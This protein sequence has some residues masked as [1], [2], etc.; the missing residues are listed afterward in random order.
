MDT[1]NMAAISTKIYSSSFWL[2]VWTIVGP[3]TFSYHLVD[4]FADFSERPS[5]ISSLP[6]DL[7]QAQSLTDRW[8]G[9]PANLSLESPK[10]PDYLPICPL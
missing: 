8:S 1:F 7:S 6:S 2:L 10:I 4:P 5:L 3:F 9:C